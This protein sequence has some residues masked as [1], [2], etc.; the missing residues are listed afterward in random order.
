MITVRNSKYDLN[1]DIDTIQAMASRLVPY[2]YEDVVFGY[3][4]DALPKLTIG[5]L[6]MRLDRLALMGNLLS[7]EQ[8]ARL[9]AAQQ[10]LDSVKHEWL[11]AYTNKTTEEL[12]V[13]INEWNEFFNECRQN[14][15]DCREVY[16]LMAEKRVMAQVL[17]NEAIKLDAL[18]PDIEKRL[19]TIDS[20]LQPY[21]KPGSFIWDK[22]LQQSYPQDQY[23]FLYVKI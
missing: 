15:N 10:K 9:A 7:D 19:N 17:A 8:R 4:P 18:T 3:M 2:V 5:G 20:Q 1:H 22:Q 16:S 12:V 21:F 23:G 11:V 14:E 13:R 6:L